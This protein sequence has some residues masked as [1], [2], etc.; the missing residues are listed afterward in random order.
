MHAPVRTVAPA[1]LPVALSDVRA[2][3]SLTEGD[4]DL[5]LQGFLDAAVS[6]LDGP[7]GVLGRCMIAQTWRQDFDAWAGELRLPVPDITSATVVYIDPDGELQTVDAALY[8]VVNRIEGA[9]IRFRQAFAQPTVGPE[10]AGVRIT[11]TAGFGASA[12]SVPA[13]IRVAIM[14]HAAHLFLNREAVAAG[15]M[16]EVPMSHASLIAPWRRGLI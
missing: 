11:F 14:T 6:H 8:D 9:S 15:Q 2:Q 4:H 5:L 1:V 3:V 7:T 16:V 10:V 13:A 12:V